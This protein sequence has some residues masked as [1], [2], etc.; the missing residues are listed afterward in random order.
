MSLRP[1]TKI[2]RALM[3]LKPSARR[4]LLMLTAWVNAKKERR[5]VRA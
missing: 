1:K 3:K 4:R 5:A 2:E